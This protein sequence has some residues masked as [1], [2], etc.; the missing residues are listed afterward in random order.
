[1]KIKYFQDSD[2]LHIEF[3]PAEIAETRDLDENT[4]LDVDS[5][6]NIC[7]MTMEHAADRVEIPHFSFEQIAA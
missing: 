7:G 6:G 5:H 4:L 1:M 3:R 2:T